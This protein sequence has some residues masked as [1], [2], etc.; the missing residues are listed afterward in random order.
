[1]RVHACVHGTFLRPDL[2]HQPCP[3][4]IW[5]EFLCCIHTVKPASS[6][7]SGPSGPWSPTPGSLHRRPGS[8]RGQR[9]R[10]LVHPGKSLGLPRSG[11]PTGAVGLSS[12]HPGVAPSEGPETRMQVQARLQQVSRGWP[13]AA[14]APRSPPDGL[15][16]TF[17]GSTLSP[18]PEGCPGHARTVSTQWAALSPR[19]IS[20]WVRSP[21][22]PDPPGRPPL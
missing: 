6:L 19:S 13:S 1:M 16:D 22:L 18:A 3:P 10:V 7:A 15:P 9:V 17:E 4:F 2:H 20:L 11:F 5:A 8:S 21:P 14:S 12:A